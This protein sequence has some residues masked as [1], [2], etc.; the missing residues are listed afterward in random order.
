MHVYVLLS[1]ETSFSNSFQS[2]NG[3]HKLCVQWFASITIGILLWIL[4]LKIMWELISCIYT[5]FYRRQ[6]NVL[7]ASCCG[8]S[9]C[10][11]NSATV[12]VSYFKGVFFEARIS[13]FN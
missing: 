11:A 4:I 5:L 7:I 10:V 3:G 13:T 9:N 6:L 12:T 2:H 8:S 1:G